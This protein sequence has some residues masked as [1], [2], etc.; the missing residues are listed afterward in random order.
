ME[1]KTTQRIVGV[2]VVI[3]L[4]IILLPLLMGESETPV[5]TAERTPASQLEN[6][7]LPDAKN[8]TAENTATKD[9]TENPSATQAENTTQN[10]NN[11]S[12]ESV[13]AGLVQN[14]KQMDFAVQNKKPAEIAPPANEN[15]TTAAENNKSTSTQTAEVASAS[16]QTKTETPPAAAEKNSAVVIADNKPVTT[17][18]TTQ[19]LEKI[20][21]KLAVKKEPTISPP[22][23]TRPMKTARVAQV[24][25]AA[26]VVQMGSFK[27]KENAIR[28]V[29]S[30]RASGYKA[31]TK[32]FKT[33]KG[34]RVRVYVGPAENKPSAVLLASKLED[35]TKLKG[36]VISY[37]PLEI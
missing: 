31:F 13:T 9:A 4:A 16:S 2:F 29:N 6:P 19:T 8:N 30:L 5:E 33:A 10:T 20:S 1:K 23:H 14:N 17:E 7:V 36:I 24:K 18:N 21:E 37:N 35:K 27:Q 32:E 15:K 25:R 28:L 34:D 3:A 12:S 11:L 26:W 22:K